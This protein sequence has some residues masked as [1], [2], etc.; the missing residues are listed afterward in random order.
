MNPALTK[1]ER[2]IASLVALGM[3]NKEISRQLGIT[4]TTVRNILRNVFRKMSTRTRT[5]L[6][7]K[8]IVNDG[9]LSPERSMPEQERKQK[10]VRNPNF[11]RTPRR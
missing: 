1:R 4:N 10:E 6:A 7:V 8:L 3:S 9:I 11:R 5:D 2:E